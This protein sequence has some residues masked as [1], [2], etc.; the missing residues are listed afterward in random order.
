MGKNVFS[1]VVNLL[2][3]PWASIRNSRI[4]FVSSWMSRCDIC[5]LGDSRAVYSFSDNVKL[6]PFHHPIDRSDQI[7]LLL[8]GN[9]LYNII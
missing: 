2:L 4:S 3:M 1:A 7:V 9:E 5:F 6:S 8:V